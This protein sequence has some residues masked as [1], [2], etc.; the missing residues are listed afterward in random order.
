[1]PNAGFTT[2]TAL[3]ARLLPEAGR[4]ET[5][6]DAALG[7]LGKAI[8]ERMQAYCGR[9]FGRGANVADEFSALSPCV[10][11]RRYPVEG[12]SGIQIRG[13]TGEPEDFEGAWQLDKGA[14]L[15][16]FSHA[17]GSRMERIIIGYTGGW[18]LDDGTAMPAGATAMPDDLLEAWIAE[19][20]YHAEGRGLF[21]AVGLRP[22]KDAEK[23][24]E[25]SG[26]TE[27]AMEALR[28]YR[29]FAGE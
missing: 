15:V 27:S 17:P 4:D 24:G 14:G 22:A 25:T 6:W 3:K 1:M 16:S 8:A 11:L 19:V 5:T 21:E 23:R 7:S 12:I 28:P 2:L 20:Q 13:F 26:L 18:W 29:R 9:I 10:T